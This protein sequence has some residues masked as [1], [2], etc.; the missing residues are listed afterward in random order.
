MQ[1][2]SR[3]SV[4]LCVARLSR[5]YCVE[6]GVSYREERAGL[7]AAQAGLYYVSHEVFCNVIRCDVHLV[8]V[9]QL[10]F[11]GTECIQLDFV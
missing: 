9:P 4:I 1:K 11:P 6:L 3:L 10:H 2:V 8:L 5:H 7:C